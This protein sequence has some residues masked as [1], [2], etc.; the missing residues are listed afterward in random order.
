MLIP[1]FLTKSIFDADTKSWV[2]KKN[3]EFFMVRKF[4]NFEKT[5]PKKFTVF[6]QYPTFCVCVESIFLSKQNGI[7]ME[8][9]VRKVFLYENVRVTL[10][11]V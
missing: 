6:H 8:N 5:H 4:S 9:W 2:L 3:G 7:Y 10:I 1:R 11:D